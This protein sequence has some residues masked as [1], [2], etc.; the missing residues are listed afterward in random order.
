MTSKYTELM[1]I[2]HGNVKRADLSTVRSR[3]LGAL[4]DSEDAFLLASNKTK[5]SDEKVETT[6]NSDVRW[7]VKRNMPVIRLYGTAFEMTTEL[8]DALNECGHP[9]AARQVNVF[10]KLG[11]ESAVEEHA[12][13]ISSALLFRKKGD[14][15]A[16]W[17]M[18]LKEQMV[19]LQTRV[20]KKVKE[21]LM[22]SGVSERVVDAMAPLAIDFE[23]ALNPA[24][25]F[26]KKHKSGNDY[27][28][29]RDGL[30]SI[31]FVTTDRISG[32][33]AIGSLRHLGY[34]ELQ[35]YRPQPP[36]QNKKFQNNKRGN[37]NKGGIK[38]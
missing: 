17:N 4:S 35:P 9:V 20:T 2:E 3:V 25:R 19:E 16:F 6:K 7:S 14:A 32:M 36:R 22:E 31:R 15:D 38:R 1:L 24:N 37:F 5:V 18:P 21:S 28:F 13:R 10:V 30:K 33:L 11:E 8:V 23:D 12:Y 29:G 27:T 34:G 26:F